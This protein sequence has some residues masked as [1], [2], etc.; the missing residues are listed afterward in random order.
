MCVAI[1]I[2]GDVAR[3]S[4]EDF[5]KM[6]ASN[7][8]GAGVGWVDSEHGVVR[9]AKG[10]T[11]VQVSDL[12]ATIPGVPALVH[13]RW[14]SAG[15]RDKGLCHPFPLGIPPETPDDFD[16]SWDLKEKGLADE[17]LIHN[18]HWSN[19]ESWKPKR[20]LPEG[21]WSDT[22]LAA[23][24]ADVQPQVLHALGGKV[25]TM[26]AA[27]VE[28]RGQ[29]ETKAGVYY[30]NT[31][32]QHSVG[33]YGTGCD[34]DDGDWR[35]WWKE[36]ARQDSRTTYGGYSSSDWDRAIACK[37]GFKWHCAE[38]EKA[39]IKLPIY[40]DPGIKKD[41]FAA[42]RERREKASG[43]G[44]PDGKPTLG[45]GDVTMTAQPLG[46]GGSGP[47]E[48]AYSGPYGYARATVDSLEE[49]DRLMALDPDEVVMELLRIDDCE[50]F[51][52]EEAAQA[53]DAALLADLPDDA[54]HQS[55]DTATGYARFAEEYAEVQKALADQCTCGKTPDHAPSLHDGPDLGGEG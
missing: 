54:D 7:P 20:G 28:L 24:L 26:S 9:W 33:M 27:R 6:E 22:R 51:D 36:R 29:W 38:C 23:Y 47:F 39:G 4:L 10:L 46:K 35:D 1:Y 32:W 52:S 12:L 48:V 37:H 18:G 3:P 2:P 30:S 25:A 40:P 49:V 45:E 8:H 11:A 21:P 53:A 17:I 43:I 55:E 14:A 16:W 42:V 15:G 50:M 19:W 44:G 41:E 31:Y 34:T 5:K 13:F